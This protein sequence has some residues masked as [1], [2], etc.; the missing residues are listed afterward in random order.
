MF[1][2]KQ[3]KSLKISNKVGV[4]GENIA[5]RFLL[6]KNYSIIERNYLEKTGE[7]DIICTR[8]KT[9]YFVEVKA[10]S[11]SDLSKVSSKDIG[12]F[13]MVTSKKINNMSKTI[14]I[15]LTKNKVSHETLWQIMVFGVYIDQ[16]NKQSKVVVLDN[17]IN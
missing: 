14:A 3:N 5:V 2:V 10:R 8:D 16:I 15:Y 11:V 9:F 6:D 4:L 7:I 12:V 17:V 1:H 13:E